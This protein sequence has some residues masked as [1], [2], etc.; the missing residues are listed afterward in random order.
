M[1]A[2]ISFLKRPGPPLRKVA[3]SLSSVS[4][5]VE[6]VTVNVMVIDSNLN[7]T[8]YWVTLPRGNFGDIL[9]V[10]NAMGPAVPTAQFV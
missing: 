6:Q 1:T 10:S 3:F 2:D 9:F 5:N 4:S 8:W 7:A